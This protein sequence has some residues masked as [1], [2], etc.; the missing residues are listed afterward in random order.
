M[1]RGSLA[2]ELKAGHIRLATQS[3]FVL[4]ALASS[5]TRAD[6]VQTVIDDALA[7]LRKDVGVYCPLEPLVSRLR[8]KLLLSADNLGARAAELAR[9]GKT[10]REKMDRLTSL[11]EADVERAVDLYLPRTHRLVL[12]LKWQSSPWGTTEVTGG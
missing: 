1:T 5:R 12:E 7:E 8:A 2:L 11:S 6:E 3:V 10:I 9:G 4:E